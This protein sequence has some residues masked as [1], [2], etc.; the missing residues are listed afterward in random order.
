[1]KFW[2][3]AHYVS[4]EIKVNANPATDEKIAKADWFSQHSLPEGYV[5]PDVLLNRFWTDLKDGFPAPYK[6]RLRKS[7]F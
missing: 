3:V 4:G 7:I 5:F 2:F 1:M 6:L